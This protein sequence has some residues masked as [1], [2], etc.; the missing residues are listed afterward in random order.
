ME[1]PLLAIA[2][3]ASVTLDGR[4]ICVLFHNTEDFKYRLQ[5]RNKP[6]IS[7]PAMC[8]NG[9]VTV[10]VRFS[11]RLVVVNLPREWHCTGGPQ[12]SFTS[13]GIVHSAYVRDKERM[14]KKEKQETIYTKRRQKLGNLAGW[15]TLWKN[16]VVKCC[17]SVRHTLHSTQRSWHIFGCLL[18]STQKHDTVKHCRNFYKTSRVL[19]RQS[20][21][22]VRHSSLKTHCSV[23]FPKKQR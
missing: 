13:K 8:P 9:A 20:F 17:S 2:A 5:A 11:L 21:C 4:G 12:Y 1:Q 22:L 14:P 23:L 19:P 16:K 3:E 7:K 15:F 6:A 18:Q 10:L